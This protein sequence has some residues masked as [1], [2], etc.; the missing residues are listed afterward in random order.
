MIGQH[1]G[2]QCAGTGTCEQISV[3][4]DRLVID[5]G[6]ASDISLLSAL[7]RR[8]APAGQSFFVA[9]F[10]PGA[11]ALFD[12]KAPTW[13]IYTA[14][15]RSDAF[16]RD[17][18][19]RLQAARPAFAVIFDFPLDGRDELRYRNSHP[20]IDQYVR[21]NFESVTGVTANPAYNIYRNRD[22]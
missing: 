13:E 5:P 21:Q 7:K 12:A 9:P 18:I 4:S 16:Q 8:F 10:W 22:D 11:Y 6:T 15:S 3:G 20:L 19:G 14:W 17:E 1:P 2:W